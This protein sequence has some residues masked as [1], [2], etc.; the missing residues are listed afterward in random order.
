MIFGITWGGLRR[1]NVPRLCCTC[2]YDWIPEYL[3]LYVSPHTSVCW[4]DITFLGYPSDKDIH[5]SFV[6]RILYFYYYFL[7]CRYPCQM[8][9]FC[10]FN[11]T[12][13]LLVFLDIRH[14]FII[15]RISVDP[16]IKN[17]K[18]RLPIMVAKKCPKGNILARVFF[19][20]GG[21][22]NLLKATSFFLKGI[23]C[24]KYSSF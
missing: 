1:S 21:P 12:R 2:K 23:F 4:A 20:F 24:Y 19:F 17:S 6:C 8:S 14:L 3:S 13:I 9:D 7:T 18:I 10:I 22:K 15:S 16:N 11:L 5:L